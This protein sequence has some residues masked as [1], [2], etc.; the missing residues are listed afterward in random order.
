MSILQEDI[1]A[2]LIDNGMPYTLAANAFWDKM[3][4]APNSCLAVIEYDSRPTEYVESAVSRS[5]QIAFR[6]NTAVE[7]RAKAMQAYIFITSDMS[8]AGAIR[9]ND[10][11]AQV[12]VRETPFKM[13]EDVNGCVVYGFNIVA[14]SSVE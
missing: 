8:E 7:A 10:R 3:P 14:R 1:I 12:T 2:Y 11:F 6:E 13:D 4:A 5:L 9:F